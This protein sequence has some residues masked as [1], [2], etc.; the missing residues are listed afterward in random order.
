MA[1]RGKA[2]FIAEA[3]PKVSD[4]GVTVQSHGAMHLNEEAA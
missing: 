2:R 1:G 3:F 4:A